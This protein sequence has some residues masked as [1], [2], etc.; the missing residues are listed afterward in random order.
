MHL[1]VL[2]HIS[3]M[4]ASNFTVLKEELQEYEYPGNGDLVR[5]IFALLEYKSSVATK[6]SLPPMAIKI[7]N[8]GSISYGPNRKPSP[9]KLQSVAETLKKLTQA[10]LV[11]ILHIEMQTAIRFLLIFILS[12]HHT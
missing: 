11:K 3:A 1:L 4:S 5:N 10:N 7:N 9:E 12:K 2:M 8:I 6:L